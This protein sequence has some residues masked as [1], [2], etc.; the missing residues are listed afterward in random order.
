MSHFR[1][2]AAAT[3]LTLTASSTAFAQTCIGRPDLTAM[4]AS[5]GAEAQFADNV[6]AY[7]GR[8]GINNARSFAGLS[9]GYVG[10]DGADDV[11]ATTFGGDVGVERH[12]GTT[13]RVHV[14][15]ILALDYQN[16]P[17]IGDN[18]ASALSGSLTAAFGMSFPMTPTVSFVPF[19][20]AGLQSVRSKFEVSNTSVSDTET[21]GILGLG[22]GFRF[23]ERFALIPSVAIPLG[24]DNSDAIFSLGATI[25]F[26]RN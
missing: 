18:N 20:R 7:E 23:N 16:G 12:Y 15:P 11:N 4:R 13:R 26:R 5:I 2:L 1:M 3:A 9:V 22:A 6:N 19:A 25:G 8:I 24:F 21:G 10:F 14:C 17:N